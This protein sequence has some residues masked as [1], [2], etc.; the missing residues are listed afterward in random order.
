[1]VRIS[2]HHRAEITEYI[3][4][5]IKIEIERIDALMHHR[6]AINNIVYSIKGA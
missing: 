3:A 2:Q 6:N 5:L 1:M 4:Q